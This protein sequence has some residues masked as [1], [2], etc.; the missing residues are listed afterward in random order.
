MSIDPTL[1]RRE[2]ARRGTDGLDVSLLWLPAEDRLVVTV[3]D[4]RVGD[5]FEVPVGAADRPFDV[6]HHPYAYAARRGVAYVVPAAQPAFDE[7]EEAPLGLAIDLD[8]R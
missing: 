3:W 5:A 4:E 7:A 2:L 6:F 8:E 1:E